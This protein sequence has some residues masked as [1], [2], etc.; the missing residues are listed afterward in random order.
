[1]SDGQRGFG[2]RHSAG[3]LLTVISHFQLGALDNHLETHL[4]SLATWRP[5]TEFGMRVYYR[6]CLHLDSIRLFHHGSQISSPSESS[7]PQSMG[8]CFSRSLWMG[9]H[10]IVLYFACP[11]IYQILFFTP[12][13]LTIF[14]VIPFLIAFFFLSVTLQTTTI[15][16]DLIVLSVP[17]A[18]DLGPIPVP[19]LRSLEMIVV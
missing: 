2:I 15:D 8:F 10:P 14:P 4:V 3:H 6:N 9:V 1:M 17:L 5:S 19:S 12:I 7:F 18:S 16:Q 13:L 11:S